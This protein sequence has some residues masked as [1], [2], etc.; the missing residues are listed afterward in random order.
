MDNLLAV[1]VDFFSGFWHFLLLLVDNLKAVSVNFF[2]DF[3]HFL[4]LLV[5]NP[6]AISVN[7]FNDF[8]HFLLLL[9]DNP[10]AFRTTFLVVFLLFS[11]ARGQ[12]QG[13]S[14]N[15]FNTFD[16][17][18]SCLWTIWKRLEYFWILLALFLGSGTQNL[19][20]AQHGFVAS[21]ADGSNSTFGFLINFCTFT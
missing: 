6:K 14:A 12:F 13:F 18:Y 2:N 11:V 5:D 21:G 7:F 16:A 17:F 8:W 19:P 15:F 3:W 20:N 10:K 1:L 9:V 4:L